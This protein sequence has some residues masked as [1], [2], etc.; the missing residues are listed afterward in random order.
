MKPA[1]SQLHS[2]AANGKLDKILTM[3]VNNF[4]R[5][6][7]LQILGL[8]KNPCIQAFVSAG[9]DKAVKVR[10]KVFFFSSGVGTPCLKTGNLNHFI[11]KLLLI[12][13]CVAF[14]DVHIEEFQTLL[15][16]HPSIQELHVYL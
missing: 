10:L 11:F 4:C 2:K 8:T 1:Y 15:T 3:K 7:C 12:V 13:C 14:E 6:I 5:E 16:L 9:E